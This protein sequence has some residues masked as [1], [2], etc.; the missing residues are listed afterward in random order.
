MAGR[1]SE[2]SLRPSQNTEGGAAAASLPG[3][4]PS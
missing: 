2:N 4:A 1:D 3:A